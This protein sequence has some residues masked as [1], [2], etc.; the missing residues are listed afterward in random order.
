[1]NRSERIISL[2]H[3]LKKLKQRNRQAEKALQIRKDRL[4]YAESVRERKLQTRRQIMIGHA[5]LHAIETD[6][7]LREW[8]FTRFP[9]HLTNDRDRSLFD[10]SP[11][12]A[13]HTDSTLPGASVAGRL[14]PW[15]RNLSRIKL[16]AIRL[17]TK[18]S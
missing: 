13:P 8:F 18:L 5:V 1:M 11:L 15:L 14:F 3:Q 12:D 10:F 9:D 7:Y 4:Q 17:V 2:D 16:N 6:P